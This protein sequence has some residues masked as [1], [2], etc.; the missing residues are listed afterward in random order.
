MGYGQQKLGRGKESQNHSKIKTAINNEHNQQLI[1]EDE[2]YYLA[3]AKSGNKQGQ[4]LNA[5]KYSQ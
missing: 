3:A 2:Q 1:A 5:K 4:G